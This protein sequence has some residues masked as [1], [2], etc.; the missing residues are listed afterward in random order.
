MNQSSKIIGI[1]FH[2]T[3]LSSLK[4]ALEILGYSVIKGQQAYVQHLSE[5]AV[6]QKI[7]QKDYPDLLQWIEPYQATVDNPWNILFREIDQH[8]SGSKFILT[9]RDEE[10]WLN[11]AK[12]YFQHRPNKAIRT[13]IYGHSSDQMNDSIYLDRYRRH[14]A[15]VQHYFK[16]RSN[17]L[18]VMDIETGDGWEKLCPFLDKP[19]IKLPFP[20]Q[21]TNLMT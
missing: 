16:N 15:A 12:N 18:L 17:D 11:S 19:I 8:F 21:N 2:K 6:I 4:L 3:G 1:G 20:K 9:L 10:S 7:N 5:E 13:W 14:H